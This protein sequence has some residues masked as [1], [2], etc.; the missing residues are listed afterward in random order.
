M[1][2]KWTNAVVFIS[3]LLPILFSLVSGQIGEY[4]YKHGFTQPGDNSLILYNK[5]VLW[6]RGAG[7]IG[8]QEGL[9]YSH[10]AL[11][12]LRMRRHTRSYTGSLKVEVANTDGICITRKA[13]VN[14]WCFTRLLL[15]CDYPDKGHFQSLGGKF[16]NLIGETKAVYGMMKRCSLELPIKRQK[17]LTPCCFVLIKQKHWSTAVKKIPNFAGLGRSSMAKLPSWQWWQGGNVSSPIC[18]VMSLL[19]TLHMDQQGTIIIS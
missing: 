17:N 6:L 8:D 2:I 14:T 15:V 3:G 7:I 4:F 10:D 11:N 12:H 19:L 9:G 18:T 16:V 5:V 13:Y 1:E